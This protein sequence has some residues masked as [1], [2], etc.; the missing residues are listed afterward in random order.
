MSEGAGSGE[1]RVRLRAV[2]RGRV[3]G[4]WFRGATAEEARRRG[5]DGW[6]RNRSDGAVEAVFEGAPESVAALAGFVRRGPPSA[7][8]ESVELRD[9]VPLGERGFAVRRSGE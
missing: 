8:V 9:E 5:V 2:I 6:V 7:R 4:V 1:S 3:Q